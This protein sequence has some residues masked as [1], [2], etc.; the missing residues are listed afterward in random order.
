MKKI[1]IFTQITKRQKNLSVLLFILIF[2]ITSLS[3]QNQ[4][5]DSL[6][7]VILSEHNRYRKIVSSQEIVWS[8]RLENSALQ[9]ANS[10]VDKPQIKKDESSSYGEN[11]YWCEIG[12]PSENVVA[13]WAS[14]QRYYYGENYNHSNP[15][16]FRNYLQIISTEITEVGCVMVISKSKREVWLCRYN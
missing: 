9:W 13:F 1:N 7:T 12:T 16:L 2:L 4:L 10:L 3:A 8:Q 5:N 11:V 6:K 15:H 14:G